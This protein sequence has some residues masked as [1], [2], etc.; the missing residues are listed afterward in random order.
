MYVGLPK[1]IERSIHD[2]SGVSLKNFWLQFFRVIVMWN[3]WMYVLLFSLELA[4]SGTN[5]TVYYHY[6][7]ERV[8]FIILIKNYVS[9]KS[10]GY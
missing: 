4:Q 9:Y 1:I 2:S 3:L 7:T 10:F 8:S 5:I 6:G